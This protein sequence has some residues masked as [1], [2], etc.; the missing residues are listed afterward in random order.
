[1]SY[2][3]VSGGTRSVQMSKQIVTTLKMM[4]LPEGVIIPFFAK[5]LKD[6]VFE[7]GDELEKAVAPMLDE[8]HKWAVALKTMR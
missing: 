6:G 7:G 1:M 4:P 5:M 3:G 8:L 2:G